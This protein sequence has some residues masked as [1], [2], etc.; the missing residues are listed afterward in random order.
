MGHAPKNLRTEHLNRCLLRTHTEDDD[1][2]YRAH[3]RY[4]QR[5][6][7][8]GTKVVIY[9]RATHDQPCQPSAAQTLKIDNGDETRALFLQ[10]QAA[11]AVPLPARSKPLRQPKQALQLENWLD[12][13]QFSAWNLCQSMITAP[14]EFCSR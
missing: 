10:T 4:R 5:G 8:T 7:H 13:L 6:K 14:S 1:K 9:L 3:P 2:K 11:A 12:S